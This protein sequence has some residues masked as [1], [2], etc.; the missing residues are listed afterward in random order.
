MELNVT[1]EPKVSEETKIHLQ[2]D[3]KAEEGKFRVILLIDSEKYQLG[4][5]QETLNQAINLY[6]LSGKES[7]FQVYN[8]KGEPQL[9]FFN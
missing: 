6:V 4:G 3:K 8:D 7:P 2:S 5:D 9:R 1:E